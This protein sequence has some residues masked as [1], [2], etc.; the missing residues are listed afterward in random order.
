MSE[1][2]EKE[3]CLSDVVS[4]QLSGFSGMRK[5]TVVG[6][7]KFG[8]VIYGPYDDDAVLWDPWDVD[9]CNGAWNED[10]DEYF[11]VTTQWHPY[12]PGCNGPTNFPEQ[13]QL[14]P[15]CSTNGIGEYLTA[16][17]TYHPTS[18][19]TIFAPTTDPTFTPTTNPITS[20]PTTDPTTVTVA[21]DV[22][23]VAEADTVSDTASDTDSNSDDSSSLASSLE[24]AL[25]DDWET[26]VIVVAVLVVVIVVLVGVIVYLLRTRKSDE[27]VWGVVHTNSSHR[28]SSKFNEASYA[29]PSEDPLPPPTTTE[30]P[31]I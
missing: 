14:Y 13:E 27:K 28:Q 19:P 7:S 21:I 12:G 1:C 17:P 24:S 11:Y 2:A 20:T 22:Q 15:N 5:K 23:S 3:D 30:M 26:I 10:G 8:H 31:F 6:L 29:S 18:N 25:G 4:W 16:D 9:A